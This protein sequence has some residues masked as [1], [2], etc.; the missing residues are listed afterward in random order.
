M[1]SGRKKTVYHLWSVG[2]KISPTSAAAGKTNSCVLWSK[3]EELVLREDKRETFM[4]S[5]E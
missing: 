2:G 4:L 5:G 3:V 1:V